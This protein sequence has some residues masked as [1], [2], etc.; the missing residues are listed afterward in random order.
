M[1]NTRKRILVIDDEPD[2][3]NMVK[4]RLEAN[5]FEVITAF[6]G[7]EGF[8]K[9]RFEKPNLVILDVMLP[10]MGG[11]ELCARIKA[12][13]STMGI[14]VLMLTARVGDIDKKMGFQCGADSYIPK[15][16]ES[17]TLLSEVSR[18]LETR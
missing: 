7:D 17:D 2:I 5:S 15:P 16:F 3:T 4:V 8:K 14:P 11:Y 6:D 13:E 18:L 12:S 10:G 9:L 1:E